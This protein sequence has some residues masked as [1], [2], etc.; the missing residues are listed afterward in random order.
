MPS[1]QSR[2]VVHRP[3]Q[4]YFSAGRNS[5]TAQFFSA[6][7]DDNDAITD[8][9]RTWNLSGLQKE[10]VRQTVRCHKKIGKARQRLDKANQEVERLTSDPNVSLKELEQ[11]PNV[12][13]LEAELQE[14]QDRLKDLNK[15]EVL[16]V[17]VKA[18]GKTVVLPDHVAELAI[19]LEVQDETPDRTAVK[20]TKK[21]KGPRNMESFRLPYRRYYTKNKTEIRVRVVVLLLCVWVI[22]ARVAHTIVSLCVAP[23]D[24]SENKQKTMMSCH[25]RQNIVIRRIG[26]C[27][28]PDVRALMS[29]FGVMT[30]TWMRKLS[31]TR[32]L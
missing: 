15:L 16:L 2:W 22:V 11:C 8:I 25:Y 29:S 14:L 3:G 1:L 6:T 19:R 18:K 5:F 10:V 30:K 20:A 9:D 26:G 24:R 7:T 27:T 31:W 28:L 32:Q 23:H 4:P 21:E 12:E 13:A 17:D